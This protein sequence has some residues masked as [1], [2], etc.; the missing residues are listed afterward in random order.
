MAAFSQMPQAIIRGQVADRSG[1]P[2][3]AAN[4]RAINEETGAAIEDL[5]GP[6]GEYVFSTLK[7]G[8]YRV[9]AEHSGFQKYIETEIRLTVGQKLRLDIHMNPGAPAEEMVVTEQQNLVEP[10]TTSIGT[11]IE[12][13][14]ITRF[15][16]DG[17]NFLQLS[18]LVPGAA[19]AAQGSPGTVR[20][21]FAVN[22]GGAREDSNNF[23]LD[24]A[25]NNDPKLN[26]VSINPPVDAIREFEVLTSTYDA[27]YGRSGGAQVSIALKSGTNDFHGTAYEFFR[28]AA[29]DARNFFDTGEGG[30]ARYQRNQFGFSLGGP[31]RK[32]RTFFFADYEGRRVR[33]GVTRVT[34]VPTELERSGNFSESVFPAPIN[35]FTQTP[36]DNAKIPPE[37]INGVGKA[38]ADLYPLP[39]RSVPGQNYVSSPIQRDRDDRFDLRVDHA[40]TRKSSLIARYS[41]AD[42]DLYEPFSG[43]TYASI[44]GYGVEVP[45][46]AQN[47]L[48]GQDHT[49][50]CDV[51]NQLRFAVNR[52]SSG[53]YQESRNGSLN[54]SVG[55]P[56]LSSNPRDYGL[57]L[58][59]ITGFSPIGDE[60]NNPQHSVTNLFQVTDTMSYAKSKHLFRFGLDIR[61]LQQNAYRD[62][63]SRGF[64]AFSDYGQVTGNGLADMLLGFITYSGGAILDNPQYL[65]AWSY[66][67]FF[68]D[69]YRLRRNLTLQLGVRYEYN[70]PPVDRYDRANTYDPISQSLLPVGKAGVPRG[71]YEPDRNNWAPRVGIAWSLDAANKTA[72]H[73]GYGI[74]YDQSSLAPGE[75]LY[76]NKPYFDFKVYYPLPGYPLTLNDPFPASYPLNIP[77]SATG[78]DRN[79]RAPYV[80]QW[81]L[82]MDR[83][84]GKDSRIEIAYVGSKGTKIISARDINQP[85]AS[86][87]YPN[88]RPVPQ[89]ADIIYLESRGNSSFNSL[90]AQFLQR[91]HSGASAI[92]SYTYGKSLDDNS[93]FFS[94][95]GDSNFP[96]DSSNPRAERGR[97][98]FDVRHRFSTGYSLEFPFGS[99]RRFLSDR[100]FV[101][102]VLSGWSTYGII[103]LQTG[104]PFTVFLLPENDNSNTGISSLGFGANNRPNRIASG[105]LSNPGPDAWFDTSA[106]VISNYGT[107]GNSGRNI[108]DGPGYCDFSASI[109]KDTRVRE[110]LNLQFRAELFNAFNHPSFDLPD[111]FLGSPTFGRINSAQNPRL[112][113]FGLKIIY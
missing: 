17:R 71:V 91:L 72:L 95:A 86:P 11:V 57:S 55:L 56:E 65:R 106:F 101:S 77:A 22:I 44:P 5:S 24:G 2:I 113:Q 108:L 39:N 27:T 8:S 81:N 10:D 15:P 73:A 46:R 19:P 16:L 70:T 84:L 62:V 41:F 47:I 20:G 102:H 28:N 69:N 75:G 110:G 25:F 13:H 112:I 63:Q 82:T 12:N 18:L 61:R 52:V 31:V 36:F 54:E 37:Y 99:D 90:Q 64:L 26:G 88:P 29:L 93:T 42:S 89:F 85:A 4:V 105:K 100:G 111:N 40:I 14:Q 38:I 68:Q 45:R 109:M 92:V 50:S 43:S 58:I 59:T 87:V 1:S 7:P 96:Q 53:S 3:P 23:T 98:N 33:E 30:A 6:G 51:I 94:S 80:Q 48:L 66:N 35:P 103:T 79:M 104:R 97:S 107:F 74:Y 83:Q 76:F 49:F 78:F 67:F 9:E 60:Y 32:N 34:N 21:D